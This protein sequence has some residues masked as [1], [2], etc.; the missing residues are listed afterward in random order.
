MQQKHWVILRRLQGTDARGRPT[1]HLQVLA[2]IE[3]ASGPPRYVWQPY[4]AG[5]LPDGAV[6]V[7][8]VKDAGELMALYGGTNAIPLNMVEGKINVS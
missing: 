2:G 6:I 8:D 4:V 5:K 3:R 1:M 7:D